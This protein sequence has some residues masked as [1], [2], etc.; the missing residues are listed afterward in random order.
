[1]SPIALDHA[2]HTHSR[3]TLQQSA[4]DNGVGTR[5]S[6]ATASDGQ[7]TVVNTLNDFANTGLDT[8]LISKIGDVLAT[9]ANNDTG[10]LGRD[11]CT[12]GELGL[13]VLLFRLRGRLAVRSE[14][15]IHSELIHLIEDVTTVAGDGILRG[16]HFAEVG[17]EERRGRIGF[18]AEMKRLGLRRTDKQVRCLINS[19]NHVRA[20]YV[21]GHHLDNRVLGG[22]SQ[23]VWAIVPH[24]QRT[25]RA[26]RHSLTRSSSR[27]GERGAA[28]KKSGREHEDLLTLSSTLGCCKDVECMLEKAGAVR[29]RGGAVCFFSAVGCSHAR[30]DSGVKGRCERSG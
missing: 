23:Y 24:K 4:S 28:L 14:A 1:M 22:A 21:N 8:C 2:S 20:C 15:V 5:D 9:L 6:V 26:R 12:K 10:F 3:G 18:E 19:I 16:R 29:W 13:S 17:W 27:Y 7:N 25:F 11:N 30:R